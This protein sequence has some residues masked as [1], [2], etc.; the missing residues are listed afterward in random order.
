MRLAP[1]ITRVRGANNVS[2]L[3]LDDM[4]HAVL[5]P[6]GPPKTTNP[7]STSS[8]MKDAW[9]GQSDCCSIGRDGSH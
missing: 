5:S 6:S 3:G 2:R 8:S 7:A 1:W 4:Y 9:A